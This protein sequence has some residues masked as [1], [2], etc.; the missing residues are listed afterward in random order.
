MSEPRN[1]NIG[2]VLDSLLIFSSLDISP[3]SLLELL[4]KKGA[5]SMSRMYLYT[6]QDSLT[7]SMPVLAGALA[8]ESSH[9][10]LRLKQTLD[11]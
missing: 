7:Q 4:L 5:L 8:E 11:F 9:L 2:S 3:I 6:S 1:K 10:R